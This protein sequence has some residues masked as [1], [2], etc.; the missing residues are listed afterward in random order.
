[1]SNNGHRHSGTLRVIEIDRTYNYWGKWISPL[2]TSRTIARKATIQWDK[3]EDVKISLSLVLW[4]H[5]TLLTSAS[6]PKEEK[7]HKSGHLVA[8]P[9][10]FLGGGGGVTF[11]KKKKKRG[12]RKNKRVKVPVTSVSPPS[13]L[14][15]SCQR[16]ILHKKWRRTSLSR[17]SFNW[18]RRAYGICSDIC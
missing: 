4:I 2:L 3:S 15:V 8:P 17:S 12:R 1:M 9:P 11:R 7:P 18:G 16:V 6:F 13:S 10:F 5:L 14:L